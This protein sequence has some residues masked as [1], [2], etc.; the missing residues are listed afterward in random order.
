MIGKKGIKCVPSQD[1]KMQ[2]GIAVVSWTILVMRLVHVFIRIWL[3]PLWVRGQCQCCCLLY[4]PQ[5]LWSRKILN[6]TWCGYGWR[7]AHIQLLDCNHKRIKTTLCWLENIFVKLH[8]RRTNFRGR[9]WQTRSSVKLL[10]KVG[11]IRDTQSL[12]RSS[13]KS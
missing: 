13:A 2:N 3:R 9:V 4:I 11:A 8:V 10:Q 1:G 7:Y 6:E 12:W 5:S